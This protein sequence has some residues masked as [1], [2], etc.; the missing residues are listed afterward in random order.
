[1]LKIN[2]VQAKLV[3]KGAKL[4]AGIHKRRGIRNLRTDV[5]VNAHDLK[6]R[7]AGGF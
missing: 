2:P 6:F 4:F 5:A 1:M 3:E 7:T